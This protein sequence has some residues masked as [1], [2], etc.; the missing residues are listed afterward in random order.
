MPAGTYEIVASLNSGNN[1]A[2]KSTQ[3]KFTLNQATILNA[4]VEINLKP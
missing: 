2:F 3:F 4:S 1:V